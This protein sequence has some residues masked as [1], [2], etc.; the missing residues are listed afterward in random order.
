MEFF[1]YDFI[2]SL[3]LFFT[4]ILIREY[5]IQHQ[6]MKDPLQQSYRDIALGIE[7]FIE[8]IISPHFL[9]LRLASFL[10]IKFLSKKTA[11]SRFGTSRF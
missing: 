7:L 9:W 5:I 3:A 10:K 2:L 1:Q 11:S 8:S 4:R 6:T